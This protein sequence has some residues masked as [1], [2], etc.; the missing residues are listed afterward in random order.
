MKHLICIQILNNKQTILLL[1]LAKKINEWIIF[2]GKYIASFDYFH[3]SLIVLSATGGSVS[4]ASFAT[5]IEAPV[6]TASTIFSFPF[7][8]ATGI[9]KKLLKTTRNKKK[10]DSETVMLARSKLNSIENKISKALTNNEISHEDFTTIINEKK[11]ELKKI[12]Q[13]WKVKEAMLKKII[14]L[15]KVKESA[16][17]KLS[18]KMHKYK[19]MLPYSSKFKKTQKT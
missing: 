12:L 6:G 8:I 1:R 11:C 16:S 13:W 17:L 15:K 4:V 5:V 19:T 10:K 2:L 7:S 18:D 9:V 14:W 3:K